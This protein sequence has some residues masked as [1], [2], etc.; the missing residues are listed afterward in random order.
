MKEY[1]SD[2]VLESNTP[3]FLFSNILS[4]FILFILSE[5]LMIFPEVSNLLQTTFWAHALLLAGRRAPQRRWV[6]RP[7]ES[8]VFCSHQTSQIAFQMEG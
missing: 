6:L 4:Q 8:R 2:G 7:S 1:W 3:A 5:I